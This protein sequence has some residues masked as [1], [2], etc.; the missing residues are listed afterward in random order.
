MV[1]I[2]SPF[3]MTNFFLLYIFGIEFYIN[4][5]V[6]EMH[7]CISQKN[8]AS[9]NSRLSLVPLRTAVLSAGSLQVVMVELKSLATTL[10]SVRRSRTSG[11]Q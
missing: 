11:C 2:K 7:F 4:L 3:G 8:L 9:H 10:K 1:I 6:I 5:Q